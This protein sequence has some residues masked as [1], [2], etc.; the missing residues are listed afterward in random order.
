MQRRWAA[1]RRDEKVCKINTPDL[2]GPAINYTT[3]FIF[4]V[5]DFFFFPD[6][7]GK[8]LPAPS[9]GSFV[10]SSPNVDVL[11]ETEKTVQIWFKIRASDC[12][13]PVGEFEY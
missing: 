2:I 4:T 12:V 11:D 13:L 6:Y 1:G 5:K 3:A 10:H 9:R 7:W 8:M